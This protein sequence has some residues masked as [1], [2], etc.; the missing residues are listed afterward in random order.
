MRICKLILK[1]LKKKQNVYWKKKKKLKKG[2][3]QYFLNEVDD[4]EDF[5]RVIQP[6]KNPIDIYQAIYRYIHF[7][8]TFN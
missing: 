6:E 5:F 1:K 8:K 2:N 4:L 7:F 3:Y